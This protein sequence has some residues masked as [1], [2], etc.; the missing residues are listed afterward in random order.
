M[1]VKAIG[2]F[3]ISMQSHVDLFI[4]Q[5]APMDEINKQYFATIIQLGEVGK[6]I[7]TTSL[8][9]F[10]KLI[11]INSRYTH[12]LKVHTQHAHI[13]NCIYVHIYIYIYW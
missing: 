8:H 2:L 12:T 13:I 5:G 9:S 1:H 6:Q 10:E 3:N 7:Q 4:E 11:K